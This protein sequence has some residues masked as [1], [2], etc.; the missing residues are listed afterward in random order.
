MATQAEH[1]AR[2]AREEREWNTPRM[3]VLGFAFLGLCLAVIFTAAY[4]TSEPSFP[5]NPWK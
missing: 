4:L 1:D 2:I 3:L 5:F